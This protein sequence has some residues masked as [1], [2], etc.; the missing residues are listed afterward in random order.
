[1]IDP[2]TLAGEL[3]G[4][5]LV[6]GYAARIVVGDDAGLA[7]LLNA[8]TGPG[9]A[10]I[11]LTSVPKSDFL[12]GLRPAL[13]ALAAKSAAIQGK[14]DRILAAIQSADAVRIDPITIGLLGQAVADGLLTQAQ[15][16]AIGSRIG[17]RAERLF[18]LGTVV[19][20]S[21]V[22]YALRGDR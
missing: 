17:S 20:S 14:W 3:R 11:A 9:A 18:G 15:V 22:S 19:L 21:D 12:V 6:L 7:R 4:D 10:T 5:P 2:V 1:M 8:R 13:L 16:D